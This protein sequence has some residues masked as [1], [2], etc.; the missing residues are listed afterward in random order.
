MLLYFEQRYLLR[1]GRK[2]SQG[3]EGEPVF[4]ASVI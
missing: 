1:E 2:E 4:P 3:G